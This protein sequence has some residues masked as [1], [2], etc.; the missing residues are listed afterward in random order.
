M[1]LQAGLERGPKS[2]HWRPVLNI[3]FAGQVQSLRRYHD[4][5]RN[6]ASSF[7]IPSGGIAES[8]NGVDS[9]DLLI[10]AGFLR[11]PYSGVF[12]LL[13]L[14]LRVQEKLERLI[15]KY[16]RKLSA[17]KLSLSSLSSQALWKKSGRL[18]DDDSE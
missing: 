3:P 11:Q 14:G 10:R 8:K 12:H 13:P 5:T 16:M 7:W 17:S 4:D 1:F 9:N 15:D 2:L 18:H 6:R